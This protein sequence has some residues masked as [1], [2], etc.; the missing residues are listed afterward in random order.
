MRGEKV[1]KQ[2]RESNKLTGQKGECSN[3][4]VAAVRW[5]ERK[6]GNH[7]KDKWRNASVGDSLIYKRDQLDLLKQKRKKNP[8]K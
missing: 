7:I 4:R 8:K 5:Q 6:T 1:E 3:Q 2:W